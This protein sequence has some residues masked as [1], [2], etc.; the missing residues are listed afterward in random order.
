MYQT[1]SITR[2]P[3]FRPTPESTPRVMRTTLAMLLLP[4]LAGWAF[5]GVR[6]LELMLLGLATALL[7]EL[8]LMSLR[9]EKTSGGLS[10]SAVM[11]LLLAFTL[12]AS[13]PAYLAVLGAAVAVLLGK[14]VFGGMGHYLWHPALVGRLI[15]QV[16]F[17]QHLSGTAGPLLDREHL[18]WGDI[19]RCQAADWHNFNW[20]K[21]LAPAGMDGFLLPDPLEQL[22]HAAN[23]SAGGEF[24]FNQFIAEKLP[25]L[26]QI[27]LGAAPGG[28]GATCVAL[29]ILVGLY[30]IYRGYISWQLPFF[31]LLAAYVTAAACPIFLNQG[32]PD[33]KLIFPVLAQGPAVGFTWLNL[34]ILSGAL[35]LGAFIFSL[36]M[37]SR[38]LTRRGQAL[39]GIG[40][41]SLAVL[42]R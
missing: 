10:H 14:Q 28:L 1:L 8:L 37:T 2:Q 39:F 15:L 11:G 5:F 29:I 38:P 13:C 7:T 9:Q 17:S 20:F 41:G 35:P 27:F 4:A 31:F 36:D 12:P 21:Q 22:W 34:Q 42:F 23:I 16:F 26:P 24:Q 19:F 32:L 6:A 18:F 40:A 25:S 30:A 33:E 3:P